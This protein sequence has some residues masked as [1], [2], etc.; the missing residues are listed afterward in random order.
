MVS[1]METVVHYVRSSTTTDIQSVFALRFYSTDIR[2][3]RE[4]ERTPRR[5]HGAP[6]W[7]RREELLLL[8]TGAGRRSF[9]VCGQPWPGYR[10]I[11]MCGL[12][13]A[14]AAMLACHW[15]KVVEGLCVHD[16][17]AKSGLQKS[18]QDTFTRDIA[19]QHLPAAAAGPVFTFSPR[20]R[21]ALNPPPQ[22][23]ATVSCENAQC[24]IRAT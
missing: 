23:F 9:D 15:A 1:C 12:A 8:R 3:E 19:R 2:S 10:P 6:P 11:A 13:N 5:R 21:Q 20:V 4:G 17:Y 24:H 7:L 16:V 18:G 22:K 14:A